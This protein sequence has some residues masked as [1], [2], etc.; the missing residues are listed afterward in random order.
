MTA[1]PFDDLDDYLALPRV[2]G[3]AVSGDGSRVVTT[4]A[5][6]ND[7]R[8][9]FVMA[10]WELD[11]QGGRPARR[12]T[13]GAKGESSPV[14]TSDGDVLFVSSRPTPDDDK[15]PASLWRLPASGGEA[16]EVLDLP[17]GI[18]AVRAA[19]DATTAVVTSPLLR[20]ADSIDDDR[21][22]RQMR[23]D[24][25]VTAILHAGYPVRCWDSDLGPD[26]PHLVEVAGRSDLTPQPG[27]ALRE[28][29]FDISPDGRFVVSTWRVPGP[30]ASVRSV[31]MRIDLDTG[32]HSVIADD[33]AADLENPA[34]APDGSSVAFT[35]ETVST[36]HRAPRNRCA[37]CHSGR[38]LRMLPR[39]G[40]A[41]RRRSRGRM[42]ARS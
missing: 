16:V 35:R 31:L 7:K 5:E 25:A 29:H 8:T 26:Q 3:I 24:N 41:G 10:I 1:T 2:S 12:L 20:S 40:I 38:N 39:A 37:T 11:P 19:R 32:E 17:G 22:L 15:P 21:R 30:A 28:N 42:T 33:P 23:K 34:I 13:R 9:E 4:I 27:N 36:P 6:L 18:K 14:F